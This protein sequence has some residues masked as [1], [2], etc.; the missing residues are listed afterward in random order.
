[1]TGR[2]GHNP[3][4]TR[5]VVPAAAVIFLASCGA[6]PLAF[7][8]LQV[9][10]DKIGYSAGPPPYYGYA[11]IGSV[12]LKDLPEGVVVTADSRPTRLRGAHGTAEFLP[13][14]SRTRIFEG[15]FYFSGM[16]DEKSYISA[17]GFLSFDPSVVVDFQDVLGNAWSASGSME[18]LKV[19]ESAHADLRRGLPS[20]APFE[21][22]SLPF[23]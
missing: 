6:P 23:K 3:V 9:R 10:N 14:W 16:I 4:V 12:S 18:R 2:L 17:T 22:V 1:M 15:V 13:K 8:R 7:D 19:L 11:L 5:V 21:A 20:P